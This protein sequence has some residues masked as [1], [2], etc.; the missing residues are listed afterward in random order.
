MGGHQSAKQQSETWL[1]PPEILQSLGTFTLDPCCPV[2]MPWKTANQ[3]L[4]PDDNGLLQPWTGRVWLNPPWGSKADP[5]IEK[6]ALHGNGIALLPARTETRLFF[7]YVW[8][9]ASAVLFVRGRPHFHRLNGSRAKANCGVPI[10]L[11]AYGVGN[12]RI[13]KHCGLGVCFNCKTDRTP[14]PAPAIRQADMLKSAKQ[15]EGE[16]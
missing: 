13:L 10:V 14:E 9:E 5:W 4:T 1:T 8:G 3:M 11:V 16:G 15:G 2:G 7:T 12:A 6:M